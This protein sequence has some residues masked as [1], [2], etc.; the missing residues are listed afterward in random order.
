VLD[1]MLNWWGRSVPGAIGL[2]DVA[3]GSLLSDTMQDRLRRKM[4]D[5][6]SGDRSRPIVAFGW[7][8]EYFDGRNLALR[9]VALGYTQVYWYRDGRETWEVNGLPEAETTATDW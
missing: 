5:L 1:P 3:W 8:P 4:N 2:R 7:N 6:T 9:L